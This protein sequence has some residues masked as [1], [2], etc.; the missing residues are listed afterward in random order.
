M[1]NLNKSFLK[2]Y[3]MIKLPSSKKENLIT[4][5]EANRNRIKN[6]FKDELKEKQPDFF[7]Q[8]SFS[9][10]TTV[11]P[12]DEKYDVDDGV[13]LQNLTNDFL[14]DDMTDPKTVHEWIV[15]AVDGNTKARV[16]DK[17]NC[18]RV[19]YAND[20]HI[21]LPIY[22]EQG[23]TIYLASKRSNEWIEDDPKGFNNWFYDQLNL[24]GEQQRRNI[25]YLKA[26]VDYNNF[27]DISGIMITVLV[28]NLNNSVD[29]RDD[30][31]LMNTV[32]QII[33]F[34]ELNRNLLMPVKPYDDL[35]EKS[36]DR[37]IDN[38]IESFKKLKTAGYKAL[39]LEDNEEAFIIWNAVFGDR[40]KN[41]DKDDDTTAKKMT[42]PV[43]I[44]DP[45][46]PWQ[47]V[48]LV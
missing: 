28:S 43:I 30:S 6:Y 33:S 17:N 39:E 4:S 19:V 40:F 13:Y 2:F 15:E 47:R 38:V 37:Q 27:V 16:I 3:D 12:L 42:A 35:L 18:V 41:F 34:L 14:N 44:I 32:S 26:W 5:R 46:K 31:S 29:D 1:A 36:N 10:K 25:M 45:P 48:G 8:G 20:Y 9:F 21:D 7:Q 22:C 24:N 11:N 23:K